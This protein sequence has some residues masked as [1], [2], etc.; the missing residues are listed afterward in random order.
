MPA[1]ISNQAADLRLITE[2]NDAIGAGGVDHEQ[3]ARE[4]GEGR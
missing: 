1:L 4:Y 3:A 2:V